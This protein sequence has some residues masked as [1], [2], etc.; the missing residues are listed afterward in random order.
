MIEQVVEFRPEL[1]CG[2]LMNSSYAGGLGDRSVEAELA[3]P[4]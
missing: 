2:I 3:R 4:E 1:Q